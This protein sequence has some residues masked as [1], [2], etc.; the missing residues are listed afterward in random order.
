MKL[1]VIVLVLMHVVLLETTALT[2]TNPVNGEPTN[3]LVTDA[4]V[5][6]T[7]L[8]KLIVLEKSTFSHLRTYDGYDVIGSRIAAAI[9]VGEEVLVCL[10]A[11]NSSVSACSLQ[12]DYVHCDQDEGNCV[13]TEIDVPALRGGSSVTSVDNSFYFATTDNR[14]LVFHYLKWTGY[15]NFV[16]LPSRKYITAEGFISREFFYSFFDDG[17]IYFIALDTLEQSKEIKLMRVCH[18]LNNNRSSLIDFESMFEMKL[19]CGFSS[20]SV[21]IVSYFKINRTIFLGLSDASKSEVCVLRLVDIDAKLMQAYE[22]CF[23]GT[24][25]FQLPWLQEMSSCS[26]NEVRS[27][28]VD[29]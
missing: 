23:N 25:T 10:H 19:D 8:D 12:V 14:D 29:A 5:L 20:D 28:Y 15:D 7:V 13:V 3:L 26:R 11:I 17:H 22:E 9:A 16:S 21:M 1:T 6:V 24:Y 18:E 4:G 27:T 2:I